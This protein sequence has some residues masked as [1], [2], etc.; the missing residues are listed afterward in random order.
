MKRM[1]GV[2]A[3]SALALALSVPA[4]A[5]GDHCGGAKSTTMASASYKHSKSS[6]WAGAWLQKSAAG[7]IQV[8]E[9]AKGSPAARAGLKPGDVVV[10]VNGYELA[11]SEQ[12][13]MCASKAACKVGSEVTYTVK[14]GDATKQIALKLE[15]MPAQVT[16]RF[17]SRQAQFDPVLAAV[18]M[19]E[20]N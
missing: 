10:A 4:F 19:P 5:G 14:R 8:A 6:A 18:V 17:A 7:T 11:D 16:A 12:R 15:K 9:V 3:V 1:L 13:A 20:V 2:S